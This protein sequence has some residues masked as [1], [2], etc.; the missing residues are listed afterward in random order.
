V[1]DFL[2]KL[3]EVISMHEHQSKIEHLELLEKY[4]F[5]QEIE[6]GI[7]SRG[8]DRLKAAVKD[9]YKNIF[10][11]SRID[12]GEG[13]MDTFKAYVRNFKEKIRLE[14]DRLQK[15]LKKMKKSYDKQTDDAVHTDTKN[16][17]QAEYREK[18]QNAYNSS[19]DKVKEF[20]SALRALETKIRDKN[21]SHLPKMN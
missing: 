10:D 9:D 19:K 21:T 3:D 12:R 20:Q 8:F 2:Q 1:A 16:N 15:Q 4:P 11:I 17:I 7:I 14:G 13:S 6:E 18:M 5:I